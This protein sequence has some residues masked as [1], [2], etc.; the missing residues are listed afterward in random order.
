MDELA[1]AVRAGSRLAVFPEGSISRAVGVRAFHLGA[2]RVAG[3]VGCDIVPVAI[4]RTRH[5]VRAGSYLPHR[6]D[7]RVI[8]GHPIKAPGGEFATQAETAEQVRLQV[9]SMAGEPVLEH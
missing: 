3:A 8:I 7:V 5:I 6:A 4:S 9:A 2:F 1:Q